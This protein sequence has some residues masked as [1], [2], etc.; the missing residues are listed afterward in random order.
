M[1][2][3]I[4][5]ILLVLICIRPFISEYAFLTIGAWYIS[6]LIFFSSLYLVLVKKPT[7]FP[8]RLNLWPALFTVIILFSMLPARYT[9]WSLFELFVFIPN[10]LIFYI[11]SK[12]E[13]DQQRQLLVTIF[14]TATIICIYAIYQ[15][16]IG[17]QHTLEYLS[18]VEHNS[19]LEELLKNK[20]VFATFP[21]PNIFASYV[22]M[23]LFLGIGLLSSSQKIEKI[24][25]GIGVIIM[26]LSLFYSKSIGG[27]LAFGCTFLLFIRYF[28][29]PLNFKKVN[30]FW[31]SFGTISIAG[32]LILACRIFLW[33]HLLQ[34]M[35]LH[36][37]NN[38]MIQRFYY[39]KASVNMTRNSLFTGIGWRNFGALY[40]LYKTPLANI[41]HYSHNVF[42]QI[43]AE[44]GLLGLGSFLLIVVVFLK[45][46]LVVIN[47]NIGPR[48]LKIGLFCAGC[49]FLIH[50]TIDLSFYFGQVAFFWWII[51][52]L[53][54]NYRVENS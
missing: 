1:K 18:H 15:Y 30:I 43:L 10:I 31:L 38:S 26:G 39:W 21:S 27:L 52:G 6:A 45:N 46:G 9:P 36:N 2:S 16:F 4:F 41:S 53:F 42:L 34:L 35:D 29:F 33:G 51:V 37:P 5:I 44:M 40:E 28:P 54:S 22:V 47:N 23:M 7:F 3:F 25:F 14:F 11:T 32:I 48:S 19:H 13:S 17:F 20:R 8:L 50:N 24:I 49:A 12:L